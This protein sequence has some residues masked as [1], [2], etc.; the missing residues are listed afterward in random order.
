MN[1]FKTARL[2][3]KLTENAIALL[4]FPEIDSKIELLVWMVHL[5]KIE[6]NLNKTIPLE[7]NKQKN[8]AILFA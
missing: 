7:I 5:I 4:I 2:Q 1:F 3:P 8:V 6:K